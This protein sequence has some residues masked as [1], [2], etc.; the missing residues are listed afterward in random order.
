[1]PT[2]NVFS[3]SFNLTNNLTN[4][5]QLVIPASVVYTRA[6]LFAPMHNVHVNKTCGLIQ[7]GCD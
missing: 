7:K 3:E 6:S 5:H 1:M 4:T 2:G